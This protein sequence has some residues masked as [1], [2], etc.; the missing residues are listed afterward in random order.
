MICTVIIPSRGRPNGLCK[1][2]HSLTRSVTQILEIEILVRIDEDDQKSLD[3]A[4]DFESYPQTKVFI[5]KRKVLD[6]LN[7]EMI[8]HAK[9]DWILFFNDDAEVIGSGWDTLL[10][11][12]PKKG[13]VFQPEVYQLNASI[14]HRA[15]RT[16]FPVFPNGCWKDFGHDE[17]IPHPC[18]Y[19]VCDLAE[20][21]GWKIGFLSGINFYHNRVEAYQEP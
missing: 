11:G 8:R 7:R 21:H 10:M 15:T 3:R 14:Y 9:G 2:L 19:A 1:A 5:G 12:F 17:F 6:D 20:K 4:I 16:G 18:D 13:I